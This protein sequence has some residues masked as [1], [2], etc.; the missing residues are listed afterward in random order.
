M[1]APTKLVL[2]IVGGSW[3]NTPREYQ[4]ESSQTTS[5]SVF[6]EL[7][8]NDV[9]SDGGIY[10]LE[11]RDDNKIYVT[12]SNNTGA[13]DVVSV[14]NFVSGQTSVSISNGDTVSL[15]SSSGTLLAQIDVDTTMLWSGTSTEGSS[16]SGTL[17]VNGTSLEYDIPATSSS[18]TYEL[19]ADGTTQLPIVHGSTASIGSASNFDQTKIWTLISPMGD[20]LDEIDLTGSGGSLAKKVFCNFW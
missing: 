19:K 1:T 2:P 14:G 3:Y 10:G 8:F 7:T 20:E 13:P 9:I 5:T 12:S 17:T 4:L 16:Y 15:Y 11:I 18:G 6:Y